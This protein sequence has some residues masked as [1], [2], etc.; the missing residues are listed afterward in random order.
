MKI[1]ATSKPVPSQQLHSININLVAHAIYRV[2]PKLH[3]SEGNTK[4]KLNVMLHGSL[5]YFF[6]LV[7]NQCFFFPWTDSFLRIIQWR[8]DKTPQNRYCVTSTAH[9]KLGA[10]E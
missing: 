8:K 3:I 6:F 7:L 4:Y 5:D 2:D 1:S 9:I 10:R